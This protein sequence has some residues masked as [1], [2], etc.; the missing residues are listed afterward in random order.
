MVQPCGTFHSR[1]EIEPKYFLKSNL[2][3]DLQT[4]KNMQKRGWCNLPVPSNP[5]SKMKPKL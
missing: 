1:S 4:K 2:Q 5:R 3:I